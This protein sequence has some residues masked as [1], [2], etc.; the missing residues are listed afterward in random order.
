MRKTAL[1][2]TLL[3]AAAA[4]TWANAA[5]VGSKAL[6]PST[7]LCIPRPLFIRMLDSFPDVARRLREI[8]AARLDESTR[9][10]SKLRPVLDGQERK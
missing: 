8:I 10:I 1:V 5:T 7:V 9:D 3:A 6:E 4:F 2:I